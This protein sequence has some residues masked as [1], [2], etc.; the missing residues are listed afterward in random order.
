MR[1]ACYGLP[2]D[3]DRGSTVNF[4]PDTEKSRC[5]L[6]FERSDQSRIMPTNSLEWCQQL[7]VK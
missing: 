4:L 1:S 3:F 2:P 7:D 5:T 6:R